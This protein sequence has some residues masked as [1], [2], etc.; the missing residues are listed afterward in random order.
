MGAHI[1]KWTLALLLTQVHMAKMIG[2]VCFGLV[3]SA[4]AN[5]NAAHV[6]RHK[7]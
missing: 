4:L 7:S 3:Y 1:D 5:A 2:N 6:I